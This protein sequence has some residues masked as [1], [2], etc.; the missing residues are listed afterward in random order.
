M[1][2]A[3][4]RLSSELLALAYLLASFVFIGKVER[5]KLIRRFSMLRDVIRSSWAY[6][7]IKREGLE[8]GLEEQRQTLWEIVQGRFPALESLAKSAAEAAND[9]TTLRH[10]IVQV[11]MAQSE[12]AAKKVL[13]TPEKH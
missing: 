12:E 8:E 6:Q 5:E 9:P 10:L 11:S 13:L 4:L 3:C 7:E 1:R 2:I